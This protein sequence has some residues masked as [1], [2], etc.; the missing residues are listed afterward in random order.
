MNTLR[1]ILRGLSDTLEHLLPFCLATLA[2][3]AAMILVLPGP[4]AT[5]ALF[6]ITDPR[7]AV[8][9]PDWREG[10]SLAWA[11]TRRGWLVTLI[12]LPL[13]A[14]VLLNLRTYAGSGSRWGLLTP[15]WVYLLL[16]GVTLTLYAFSLSAVT[17]LPLGSAI[18]RSA[19]LVVAFPIR[20]AVV[21]FV[22]L[23]IVAAGGLLVV[24]LVMFVPALAAAVI[25]RTVLTGLGLPIVDPLAPT[26]ERKIEEQRRSSTSRFGP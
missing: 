23:F 20:S 5:I 25:N 22:L 8:D 16:F 7:R 14:V 3:W 2:W 11:S 6:A 1:I 15:L 10:I 21:T 9:R 13:V 4:G 17:D 24:P 18:Q 12:M 26:P 19:L